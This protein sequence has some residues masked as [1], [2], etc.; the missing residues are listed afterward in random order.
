IDIRDERVFLKGKKTGLDWEQL[1]DAAYWRRVNLSAQGYYA[2]PDI[3]FDKT[4][5]K[6]KPFAYHVY[7][8]SIFE[9]TLD[10]LRGIYSI[11]AVHITHDAG[12]SLNFLIDRGQ[13]E[14]GLVQGIGWVTME[15][16]SYSPGGKLLTDTTGTYKIPDLKSTPGVV[17][18]HFIE[19]AANPYAVL[20]SK[21]I[22]EPPLMYGIG[23][24]FAI[25]EA[26][27]AF[28]PGKEKFYNS[29]ITPE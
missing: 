10:C 28:R 18:V 19:D 3:H 8:T 20:S 7:G 1:I 17:D 6:G 24:Y 25:L 14:G 13:A 5:E 23:A 21:A 15:E 9:V 12:K 27:K 16:V 22:G 11:D 2:T 29:P 26:M 4:T